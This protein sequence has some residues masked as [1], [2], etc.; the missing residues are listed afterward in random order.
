MTL[1]D[2]L[3]E[4]LVRPAQLDID[5]FANSVLRSFAVIEK[6]KTQ[7]CVLLFSLYDQLSSLP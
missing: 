1:E 5:D 7:P 3:L 2:R 6:C 4:V